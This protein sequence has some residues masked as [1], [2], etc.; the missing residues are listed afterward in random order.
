MAV[1]SCKMQVTFRT[2]FC[3]KNPMTPMCL[4][5]KEEY[6]LKVNVCVPFSHNILYKY[7][8]RNAET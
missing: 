3:F 5:P 4:G 8:Q 2:I 1:T 7:L 6:G